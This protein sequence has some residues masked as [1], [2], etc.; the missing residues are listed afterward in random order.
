MWFDH[1]SIKSKL[2]LSFAV[3]GVALVVAILYCLAQFSFI[4]SHLKTLAADNVPSMKSAGEIS[5]LRLR[6][7]VRSLE[8]LMAAP[9]EQP[10]LEKSLQE[11]DGKLS[12]AL[13]AHQALV[14]NDE[15]KQALAEAAKGAADYKATVNEAI[16]LYT[17]GRVDE[18]QVLRK[19]DWV[20]IA[21]H[22]RDQTD[23]LVKISNDG[24]ATAS[25]AIDATIRKAVYGGIVAL[26]VSTLLA[27]MTALYVAFKITSRLNQVVDVASLI[28]NGDLREVKIA[29]SRDEIGQLAESIR[30]MQ[31]SLRAT[32]TEVRKSADNVLQASHALADSSRQM[33]GSTELQSESASAIASNIE[34]LTVS[35][36][37]VTDVTHEVTLLAVGSDAKARHGHEITEQLIER[38]GRVSEVV[39]STARQIQTLESESVRISEIVETIRGIAEQTNLLALNAAIEAARAG[40]QGRGFAVVADE[41]RSLSE[42]TAKSTQEISDMVHAI[43][44]MIASVVT[45]VQD[46]VLLTNEGVSKAGEVGRAIE[47]MHEVTQ[48][49]ARIAQEVDVALREQSSASTDVAQ[50]VEQIS[51]HAE[52]T[53]FGSQ[54]VSDSAQHLDGVAREM[55][56]Y[57]ARFQI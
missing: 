33:Q 52:E 21:N 47:D 25:T 23:Q 41:V 8:Y 42:R 2:F 30:R 40:E 17:A 22:F 53:S 5:Q 36:N 15:E 11:L 49:V 19:T 16:R 12:E 7:R 38:I 48:Q 55:Q 57:V 44:S 54:G 51:I 4:G 10:K 3:A 18:A 34:E 45:Q 26:L 31:E 32:L 28:A 13:A 6:Y 9:D 24:V 29:S 46:G 50:K 56:G 35:I 20:K 43:Q 14:S 27:V 37:H 39:G 1:I